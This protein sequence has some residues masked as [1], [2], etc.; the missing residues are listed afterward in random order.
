VREEKGQYPTTQRKKRKTEGKNKEKTHSSLS[1]HTSNPFSSTQ[2]RPSARSGLTRKSTSE[3]CE[4][5]RFLFDV[6][7]D[8]FEDVGVGGGGGGGGVLTCEKGWR[9]S[10]ERE[11]REV[12]GERTRNR[13]GEDGGGEEGGGE[14]H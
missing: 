6:G 13:G 8:G 1:S 14:T 7:E 3:G 2:H 12:R 9:V 10:D 4:S 11:G 5:R